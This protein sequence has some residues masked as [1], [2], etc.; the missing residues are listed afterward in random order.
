MK[1]LIFVLQKHCAVL[2]LVFL[3]AFVQQS[4]TK[5]N[6]AAEPVTTTP[7]DNFL[8]L[9]PGTNPELQPVVE[10]LEQQFQKIILQPIFLAW[11]GQPLWN[12]TIKIKSN[13]DDIILLIPVKKENEVTA[14]IEVM[15]N[16]ENFFYGLH[17]KS[18]I[19]NTIKEYSNIGFD[20]AAVKWFMDYFDAKLGANTTAN[21][22]NLV[23]PPYCWYES[24]TNGG[25]YSKTGTASANPVPNQP[26]WTKHCAD[27]GGGGDGGGG[28]GGGG[29]FP[30]SPTPTPTPCPVN[31]G[32]YNIIPPPPCDVP[33]P[34]GCASA[35]ATLNNAIQTVAVAEKVSIL[36]L[37][38]MA[39]TREFLLPWKFVRHVLNTWSYNS[40]EHAYHK[41]VNGVWQWDKLTHESINLVG[42]TFGVEV[43]CTILD[44][45]IEVGIYNA[46]IE[47]KYNIKGSFACEGVPIASN[48]K[49][50]KSKKI[51]NINDTK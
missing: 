22:S 40:N 9:P 44:K 21:K 30:P 26:C 48:W 29:G 18:S 49:E 5:T 4:C 47:L 6:E 2:T 24:C 50:M 17:R 39:N 27:E 42:N 10:N 20:E 31:D 8:T 43:N 7:V 38:Q 46:G 33:D 1:K 16:K 37:S 41:K 32:W 14:F 36:P 15:Y 3:L 25:G 12:H 34:N 28:S 19:T 51:W 23:S 45:I 11:H 35:E 13:T